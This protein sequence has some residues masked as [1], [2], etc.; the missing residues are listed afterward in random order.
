MGLS[1]Q[2]HSPPSSRKQRQREIKVKNNY[3]IPKKSLIFLELLS[4]TNDMVVLP[5]SSTP[6]SQ[7]ATGGFS[8]FGNSKE[9]PSERAK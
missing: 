6:I 3:F 4:D 1:S 9:N 7:P 2:S 5:S 8:I